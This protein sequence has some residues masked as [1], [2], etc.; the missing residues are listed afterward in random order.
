MTVI[1]STVTNAIDYLNTLYNFSSTA[2]TSGEEEYSVWV[3][4]F[5]VAIN[6]WEKE[7]MW[8]ELFVKLADAT[9]GDKTTIANTF[10]YDTPTNFR[11][12]AGGFIWLGSNTNKEAYQVIKP[13]ELTLHANDIGMWCYFLNGHLYFNPNLTITGGKTINYE[14]YKKASAVS[15]GTDT[16][17]MSDP[18][19][20]VYFALAELKKDEGDATAAQI[21]TQKLTNMVD[22]ND[23]VGWFQS[24]SL[25]N[26]T[27]SGFGV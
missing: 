24:D 5:N 23:A 2:P 15:T 18:M 21:A 8:K 20:A 22:E 1:I 13:T 25:Q 4:L 17:D 14:Y 7:A 12:H 6:L 9:D 27:E 16:F 10:E 11:F 19:F 26:T 3:S